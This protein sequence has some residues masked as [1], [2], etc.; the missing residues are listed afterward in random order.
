MVG[1][2]LVIDGGMGRSI[3]LK[4]L[5]VSDRLSNYCGCYKKKHVDELERAMAHSGFNLGGAELNG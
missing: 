5:R 2:S 4:R 1:L 3:I